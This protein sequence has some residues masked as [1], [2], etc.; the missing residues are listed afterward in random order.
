MEKDTKRIQ[1]DLDVV[2]RF[3]ELWCAGHHHEG[4]RPVTLGET[5]TIQLC[6]ECAEFFAYARH[7]RETCPLEPEKPSCKHCQVHCYAPPQRAKVRQIMAWSGMRMLLR[8][9]LNYLRKY[10][11]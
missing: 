11:F 2:G 7:K 6:P 4:R 8:G 1:K 10:F 3:T 5:A 9:R